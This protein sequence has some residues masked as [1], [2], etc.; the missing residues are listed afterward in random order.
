MSIMSLRRTNGNGK[1]NGNSNGSGNTNTNANGNV[2]RNG[3]GNRVEPTLPAYPPQSYVAKPNA[4]T[5]QL[6]LGNVTLEAVDRLT[7]LTAVEI[8]RLAEQL[9]TGAQE[10]EAILQELARRV[11]ENGLFASERLARFVRVANQ[12]AD[13]ARTMQEHVERRDEEP[14]PERLVEQPDIVEQADI[15][16]QTDIVEQADIV[17]HAD[18]VEEADVVKKAD[19]IDFN[20]APADQADTLGEVEQQIKKTVKNLRRA[21]R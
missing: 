9:L 5:V 17:E 10:T 16:Q 13:V 3:N 15:V 20:R 8:E 21:S 2:N 11:R 12:C 4:Q 18:V 1:G 14:P 7:G 19:V 6:Q